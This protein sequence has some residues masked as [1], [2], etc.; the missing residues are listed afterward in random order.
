[1]G[2]KTSFIFHTLYYTHKDLRPTPLQKGPFLVHSFGVSF[3]PLA[4]GAHCSFSGSK[5]TA[6]CFVETAWR[7]LVCD[8]QCNC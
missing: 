1:M 4:L 3:Q 7:R 2:L 8:T 5:G 6:A